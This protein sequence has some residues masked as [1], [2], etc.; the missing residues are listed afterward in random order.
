MLKVE[1]VTA[2][3]SWAK[4]CGLLPPPFPFK[5]V[6]SSPLVPPSHSGACW[7]FVT[8]PVNVQ[9]DDKEGGLCIMMVEAERDQCI[10]TRKQDVHPCHLTYFKQWRGNRERIVGKLCMDLLLSTSQ[11]PQVTLIWS[12]ADLQFRRII[13]RWKITT[14]GWI[15]EFWFLSS[16]HFPCLKF[17]CPHFCISFL[18]ILKTSSWKFL[19]ILLQMYQNL[20]SFYMRFPLIYCYFHQCVYFNAYF[21]PIH[22]WVREQHHKF[23]EV[24]ILKVSWASVHILFQK[25]RIK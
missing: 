1:G 16:C 17:C 8:L 6:N 20:H 25:V 10:R 14:S 4:T 15:C 5:V 13:P 22:Y 7:S 9:G 3:K 19:S 21:L 11:S 23:R 18:F 2:G 24:R 12:I